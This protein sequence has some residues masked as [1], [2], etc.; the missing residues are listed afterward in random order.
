ML[1]AKSSKISGIR[2]MAGVLIPGFSIICSVPIHNKWQSGEIPQ[3]TA[4]IYFVINL[5][6]M[7]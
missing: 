5:L 3:R 6:E 2:L 1:L 7:I 4:G